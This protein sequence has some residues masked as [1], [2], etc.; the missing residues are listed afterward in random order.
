MK[1]PEFFRIATGRDPYPYQTRLAQDDWP[2]VIDVPTGLG[3]TAAVAL[4]WLWT[5]YTRNPRATTRLV[6][7]LPMR[8]LVEQTRSAIQAWL[9][10]LAASFEQRGIVLPTVDI[11]MGGEAF[12]PWA[13]APE[14]PAIII[15]TQDMLLSRALM[16]GYGM[17]QFAWPTHYAW[18]HNDALWVFDETQIM[19]VA[20]ET[21]AQLEGFRARFGTAKAVKT[22]WMSATLGEAQLDTVDHRRPAV[23]WRKHTLDATDF[24]LDVVTK[25]TRASKPI[26]PASVST[27]QA[28]QKEVAS[29]A[30]KSTWAADLAKEILQAHHDGSLTLVILNR[31]VR[32]QALHAALRAKAP[33]RTIALLHSRF[34]RPDRAAQEQTLRAE[35]DRIVVATQ[36]VEAGV[37]V[38]ART[39]FTE[40]APWPSLVQRFGRCNRYGEQSGAQIRWIDVVAIDDK[41]D[42]GLPYSVD[43]LN[44]ARRLVKSLIDVSP[45][46]LSEIPYQPPAVLRPV[47]RARDVIELFDTTPDLSGNHL[48]VAR[49]IRDPGQDS[50]ASVFWR[51][52]DAKTGPPPATTPAPSRDEIC[53][54]SLG[55]L[56]AFLKKHEAKGWAFDHLEKVWVEVRQARPG[57]M[58]LIPASLG[59]YDREQGF[60]GESARKNQAVPPVE[61]SSR[62]PES[63]GDEPQSVAR[64]LS[65]LDHARDVVADTRGLCG[66]LQ[67]DPTWTR[68]L[69]TA[70]TWHDVGKAHVTFQAMLRGPGEKNP[71]LAPPEGD[72]LWAKSNHD[73]GR[74]ARKGFRH[75][76]ASALAWLQR[77]DSALPLEDINAIAYLIATHHGKVRLSIRSLPQ[78][79]E[80]TGEQEGALFAR[81]VWHGD[82]L[83]EVRLPDGETVPETRLDLRPVQLGPGSWLERTLSLRDAPTIGPFRL[84]FY[85]ALL[86]VADGRASAR[87]RAADYQGGTR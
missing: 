47:I 29:R 37:D 31:V 30:G 82:L 35:G 46:A 26:E 74:S 19:G 27:S 83:P 78:E 6:W 3:K 43:D 40:L 5:L 68:R 23:G 79:D 75:E 34:R 54:V 72:V 65:L 67:L 53:S 8:V 44:G 41:D 25:R 1:F 28:D 17:S 52:V 32:A 59:G 57:Q 50:D 62:A 38:S 10:N 13:E 81:G 2:E 77:A 24:A 66:A 70:A 22:I 45:A 18:L 42:A 63:M 21:S 80:P 71:A 55:P 14:R 76:L 7:C 16:R 39:L 56:N 11:L 4:G 20:I 86:R 58:I 33:D 36:V 87:E 69:D 49:F 61:S 15:G 12:A 84:A 48:D 60:T 64:W 51:A 85:E 9:D 73:L